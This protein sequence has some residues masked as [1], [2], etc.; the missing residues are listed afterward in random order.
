MIEVLVAL[1]AGLL[2]ITLGQLVVELVVMVI[3]G[4]DP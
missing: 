2:S 3:R 4:G 1:G